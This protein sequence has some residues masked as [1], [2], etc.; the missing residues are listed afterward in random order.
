MAKREVQI[1][2][3]CEDRQHAAFLSRFL[4]QRGYLPRKIRVKISP[5]GKGAAEQKVRERY[6]DELRAY[7]RWKMP[8]HH[9]LIA[10]RDGDKYTVSQR[11]A[12]LDSEC[13]KQ[14]CNQRRAGEG[15]AVIVPCRNIQTWIAYLRG[16][17]VNEITEYPSLD[18]EREC[19]DAVRNLVEMCDRGELRSPAPPSL[20]AACEE[21]RSRL[22]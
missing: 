12:Q 18:R 8:E 2:I 17:A 1:V 22:S 20:V 4:E 15:V 9:K 10:V 19:G 11:I 3:I 21:Y 7:R 14:G 5:R 13:E 16:E 6:L